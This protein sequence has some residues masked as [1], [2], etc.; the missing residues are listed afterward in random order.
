MLYEEDL[1]EIV[2]HANLRVEKEMSDYYGKLLQEQLKA[3]VPRKNKS[4]GGG[5][6]SGGA[7]EGR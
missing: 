6:G 3:S 2:A 5:S 1:F 7:A 4:E